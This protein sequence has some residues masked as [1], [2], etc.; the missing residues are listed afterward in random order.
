VLVTI[1]GVLLGGALGQINFDGTRAHIDLDDGTYLWTAL[2]NVVPIENQPHDSA[3]IRT[4]TDRE[5][6]VE[7]W[8]H[9][10]QGMYVCLSSSRRLHWEELRKMQHRIYLPTDED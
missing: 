2:E 1:G 9:E 3:I 10:E 4:W 7:W 5:A 8:E 6:T